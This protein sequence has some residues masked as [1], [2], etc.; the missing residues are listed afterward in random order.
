MSASCNCRPMCSI[1]NRSMI[2]KSY[3]MGTY[4]AEADRYEYK[5][6]TR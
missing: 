3:M 4:T 6:T 5:L 2:A 1:G